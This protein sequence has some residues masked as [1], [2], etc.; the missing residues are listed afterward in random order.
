MTSTSRTAI[1]GG[2]LVA[3]D[4]TEHR[5]LREGVLV[6]EGDRIVYVGPTYAG[7]RARTVDARGKL[8]IPGQI[9]GH[10]HVS[11]ISSAPASRTICPPR[12]TAASR[13][14]ATPTGA[15]RCASGWPR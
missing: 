12:A 2:L 4:G 11:A 10:A 7:P 1:E 13:S 5:L 3:F 9:S 14:C 6:Y 8:V 15:P